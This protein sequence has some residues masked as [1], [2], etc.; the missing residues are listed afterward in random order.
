MP[1]PVTSTQTVE[2]ELENG[3][4]AFAN[5]QVVRVM[6]Q[7][8]SKDKMIKSEVKKAMNKFLEDICADVSKRMDAYPYAYIDLRMFETAI[9]PYKRLG[10][11]EGEKKRIVAHLEAIKSDADRLIR[12]VEESFKTE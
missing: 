1:E 9:E 11:V 10:R 6:R 4:M 12:D 3:D 8:I 5:A 7:A 2:E